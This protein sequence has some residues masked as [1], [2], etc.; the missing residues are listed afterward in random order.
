[1]VDEGLLQRMQRTVPGKTLDCRDIGA[2]LHDGQRQTR[3][4]APAIIKT[5]HAPH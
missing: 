1:M 4:D 2:I 3:I 5:V